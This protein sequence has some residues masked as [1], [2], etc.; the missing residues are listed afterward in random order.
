MYRT[1]ISYFSEKDSD[2]IQRSETF[3]AAVGVLSLA[4]NRLYLLYC[5]VLYV[6]ICMPCL[7]KYLYVICVVTQWRFCT[8]ENIVK[9]Q[10]CKIRRSRSTETLV[11]ICLW[12]CAFTIYLHYYTTYVMVY[13]TFEKYIVFLI[14][15]Q[16]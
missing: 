5:I 9:G 12:T 14:Y 8:L 13:N 3:V 1:Y 11:V 15:Y 10:R 2:R 4:R 7:I 16:F 6:H